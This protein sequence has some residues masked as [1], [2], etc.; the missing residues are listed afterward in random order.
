MD[1]PRRCPKHLAPTTSPRTLNSRAVLRAVSSL[2]K[3]DLPINVVQLAS[4]LRFGLRGQDNLASPMHRPMTAA[5][6]LSMMT[7][8]SGTTNKPKAVRLRWDDDQLSNGEAEWI[9]VGG[10]GEGPDLSEYLK[11]S[12][13]QMTGNLEFK[14]TGEGEYWSY[15]KA[16]RPAAWDKDN[17][18]HGLI[19]D[20]GST[21]TYKQQ[22]R[23]QGR[24]GKTSSISTTTARHQRRFLV[25]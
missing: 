23:I 13:G 10:S 3:L 24:G 19:L 20:I 17:K 21:N 22:F 9:E 18:T 6:L 1:L 15:I 2:S 8:T 12:G 16:L 14:C 25:A 4:S 5:S 11:K 7:A